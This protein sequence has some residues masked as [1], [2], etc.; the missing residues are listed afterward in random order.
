[1]AEP[2]SEH[3]RAVWRSPLGLLAVEQTGQ[4]ITAAYFCD[5]AEAETPGGTPLLVRALPAFRRYFAGVRDPFDF[6]IAFRGTPFQE[7][8]WRELQTIPRGETRSYGEIARAVGNPKAARAVGMACH[9][10]PI[11]IAVPCHRV[12]G[13]G[14]ALTG[15]GG[16]LDRKRALL[17]LEA[18]NGTTRA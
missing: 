6:P 17:A 3:F 15:Y 12:V 1:M 8:V 13:S 16:G 7:R 14:G 4:A 18:R 5:A 9:A 2:T 11:A 10:N